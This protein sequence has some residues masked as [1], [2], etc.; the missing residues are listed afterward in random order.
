MVQLFE[1]RKNLFIFFNYTKNLCKQISF[2]FEA[3]SSLLIYFL[4]SLL[5]FITPFIKLLAQ[6]STEQ[7]SNIDFYELSLEQ[8]SKI[9]ITASKTPQ[10]I[11]KITQKI[12]VVSEKDI[13]KIVMGNRNVA[14][15]I[16]YLP[17]ASVKVL[18]RNDVNWG[19]YGGIG[20]KYNTYM[21]QG[22]PIDGFMDPV[23]LSIMG[24]QRIEV[25]RGPASILYSN[26][27]S[28]DFAGNQSPLAGTVNIIV[29]EDVT[30]PVTSM[31]VEYGSYNTYKAKVF[32][33]NRFGKF[34]VLGGLSYENSDYTN[35]GTTNS[36]LNMQKN[37]EYQKI[38]IFLGT[39]YYLD[40]QEKHKLTFY[41]NQSFQLGDFGRINR[42]FDFKYSLINL[43]YSGKITEKLKLNV[44]AGLRKYYRDW[45]ED[46]EINSVMVLKET[47]GVE[48]TI[49]PFDAAFSYHHLN[50]SLLSV[51]TDFQHASYLTWI[52]TLENEKIT[53]NDASANQLGFYIQEEYQ[54]ENFTL[55]GGGRFNIIKYE[56]NKFDRITPEVNS[57]DWKVFLWSYGAKY[58]LSE[59]VFL[60]TN[61]GSS[62]LTPGLKSLGGTL[63]INDIYVP[64]KNGQLPNPDLKP[65]NGMGFDIGAEIVLFNDFDV[66]LRLFNNIINDAIIDIV[67]SE[68]PSQTK[69]INASGNTTIKGFELSVKQK[70]DENFNWFANVTYTNSKM[71]NSVNSDQDGVEIPFVPEFMSNLGFTLSLPYGLEF[72]AML[73]L[74]GII[75]DSNTKINRHSF[76]S[77]ELLNIVA[78]KEFN[79]S[80]ENKLNLFIKLYNVTNNKYEMPWQFKDPGINFTMG[81]NLVFNTF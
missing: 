80:N 3:I 78:S 25:Q 29:K 12:D 57:K 56:I 41:G 39:S 45:Q 54:L 17:G 64:N 55:R 5:F 50:N 74:G 33:A 15:L 70:I 35:Y 47:D 42:E 67:I 61:G 75:Y 16:Q 9:V 72:N 37:P 19:A 11:D 52:K 7:K 81:L 76:N 38:K 13:S 73:H 40:T 30:T 14:E 36:W 62:F 65:E 69:S 79:I 24:I 21:I 71:S 66:S 53:G 44:K 32:H 58:H 6:D 27:L 43:A 8:L 68:N 49:L 26:Y 60:F 2:F 22:L 51:G 18:S 20:T 4:F 48:Q 1:V 59:K 31:D 28:Q 10:S 23:G 34:S 77:K 63:S 46:N